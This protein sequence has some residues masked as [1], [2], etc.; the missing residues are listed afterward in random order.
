MLSACQTGLGKEVKGEGMIGMTRAFMYAGAPRVVVSLWSVKDRPT[1]E[2]MARFY[3]RMLGRKKNSPAAA[4]R[5]AQIDMWKETAWKAPYFWAG[6][7]LQGEWKQMG[8]N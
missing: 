1:S 7:I 6:F 2:L 5:A 4:L 3:K 8:V